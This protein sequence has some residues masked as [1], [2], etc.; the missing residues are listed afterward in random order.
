MT[1]LDSNGL[2]RCFELPIF[3][4]IEVRGTETRLVLEPGQMYHLHVTWPACFIAGLQ[5][6]SSQVSPRCA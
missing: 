1:I 6:V 3:P 4:D 5:C 2:A